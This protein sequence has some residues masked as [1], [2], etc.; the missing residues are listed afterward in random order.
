[1]EERKKTR[2]ENQKEVEKKKYILKVLT[3][4]NIRET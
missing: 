1:M 3:K 2:N 4:K